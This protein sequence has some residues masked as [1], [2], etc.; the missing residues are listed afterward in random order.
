MM[1]E[2]LQY[3]RSWSNSRKQFYK[4]LCERGP[5]QEGR[6]PYDGRG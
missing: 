5:H 1:E 4:T 2:D 3:I 6:W